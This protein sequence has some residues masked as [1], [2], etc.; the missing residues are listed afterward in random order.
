MRLYT[1]VAACAAVLALAA[2]GDKGSD[3]AASPAP[4]PADASAATMTPQAAAH[5]GK[6]VLFGLTADAL[7]DADIVSFAGIKLGEIE[8]LI[9]DGS[10]HLVQ[11][12]VELEG[13]QD[14]KVLVPV[15]TLF[16]FNAP[17]GKGKDLSTELNLEQLKA[18]PKYT[19]QS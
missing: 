8:S 4:A 15:N 2:C 3:K 12:A 5:A 7:E 17:D 19:P 9:F 16:L 10:G 11:V 14:E 6:P 1:T 13:P 18:L